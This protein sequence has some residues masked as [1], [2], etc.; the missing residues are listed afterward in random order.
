MNGED[1]LRPAAVGLAVLAGAAAARFRLRRRPPPLRV[2]GN[3]EGPGVYLFTA[4][5][6]DMC[7]EARAVYRRVLG[8]G[9]FTELTWEEHPYLFTDLGVEGIPRGA[10]VDA[11]GREAASFS[12]APRPAALRRA[13]RKMGR[14]TSGR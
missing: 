7:G 11:A 10:V 3:L 13:A 1:W 8:E 6:C 4:S 5:A 14:R 2:E 12:G 9:G